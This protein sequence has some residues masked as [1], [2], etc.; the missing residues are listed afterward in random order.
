[1]A[2]LEVEGEFGV[3]QLA[4]AA[5]ASDALVIDAANRGRR[6]RDLR[7]ERL[8]ISHCPRPEVADDSAAAAARATAALAAQR[9]PCSPPRS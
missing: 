8:G 1:M 7:M 6:H 4:I 3:A 9:D 5:L 2:E